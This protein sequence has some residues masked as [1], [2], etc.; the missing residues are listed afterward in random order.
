[1]NEPIHPVAAAAA[2]SPSYDEDP[3]G[4]AIAQATFV[5]KRRLDAIDW[6]NVA[7]EIEDVAKREQHAAEAHLRVLMAHILKL[8]HQPERRGKSW[9]LTI[10]DQRVSYRQVIGQNPGLKTKL[11]EMQTQAYERA[12]IEAAR[13]ADLDLAK[14]P[15]S[16]PDWSI[17]LDEPFDTIPH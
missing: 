13:E 8:Q 10:L 11:Q 3:Y 5:R 15:S 2:P 4:W 6:D 12:R 1:M 16:P 9:A 14:L 7:E 17:I